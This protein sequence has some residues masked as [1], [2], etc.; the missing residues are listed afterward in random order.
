M[1]KIFKE[2]N[3]QEKM[4]SAD[5]YVGFIDVWGGVGWGRGGGGVKPGGDYSERKLVSNSP[6]R[7]RLGNIRGHLIAKATCQNI[8]SIIRI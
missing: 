2:N 3:S 5:C 1:I 4:R 8:F 6:K 7:S